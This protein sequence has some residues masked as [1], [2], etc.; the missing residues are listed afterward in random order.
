M[1]KNPFRIKLRDGG[2][3]HF[4]KGAHIIGADSIEVD[5]DETSR[6]TTDNT[7]LLPTRQKPL[8]HSGI[9]R[10]GVGWNPSLKDAFDPKKAADQSCDPFADPKAM[11]RRAH[12]HIT[13]LDAKITAFTQDKPWSHFVEKNSDGTADLHK[14]K[15]TN[16]LSND[17]PIVLFEA[18]N[19]LRSVLV[20]RLHN[21]RPPHWKR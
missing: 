15:F 1:A 21:C 2:Q 16:R 12:H 11:L 6:I 10:S 9:A 18:A 17:L 19:A 4:R 8:T 7:A 20:G 3:I 14:I 13:D 5:S